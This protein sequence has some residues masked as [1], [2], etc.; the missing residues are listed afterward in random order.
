MSSKDE[1]HT[2]KENEHSSYVEAEKNHLGALQVKKLVFEITLGNFDSALHLIENGVEDLI[3]F[4]DEQS[5]M[6]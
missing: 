3:N 1:S 2:A 6:H 4:T 5:S